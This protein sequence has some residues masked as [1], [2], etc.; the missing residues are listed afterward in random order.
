MPVR[1]WLDVVKPGFGAKFSSAFEAAGLDLLEDLAGTNEQELAELE[2]E[3]AK[4]GARKAHLRK[5]RS[6]IRAQF[7]KTGARSNSPGPSAAN[8]PRPSLRAPARRS[9]R[10]SRARSR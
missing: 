9:P 6:A 7:P 5:L 8:A 3:L 4:V 1:V 2:E 10:R